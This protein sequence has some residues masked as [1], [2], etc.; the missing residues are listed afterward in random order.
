MMMMMMT[1]NPEWDVSKQPVDNP[2]M[3]NYELNSSILNHHRALW[4]F[5]ALFA[6]NVFSCVSATISN[7]LPPCSI[8]L[9]CALGATEMRPF[10]ETIG[11][12][13]GAFIICYPN[14]GNASLPCEA[15]LQL[16]LPLS[17]W[18][19]SAFLQV[20]PTHLEAMMKPQIALLHV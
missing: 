20:S 19:V 12:S 14:A 9:N 6:C 2:L 13:T 3:S 15:T 1:W 18:P 11:K 8:G 5:S 7:P 16:C 10:I 4:P 17:N